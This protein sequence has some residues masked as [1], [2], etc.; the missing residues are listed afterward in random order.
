[1]ASPE[2]PAGL[3]EI[4]QQAGRVVFLTG[5]GVSAESGVPTFRDALTGL[6]SN[7]SPE[8]LATPEAF[9][10]NP[11]LVWDWYRE[12][13]QRAAK[14]QPNGGHLALARLQQRYPAA[15]L[16]TQNVDGLHQR[17]GSSGVIEFHGNLFRDRCRRCEL[18]QPGDAD[19][20]LAP[21]PCPRCGTPMGPGVV[22]FGETI[23]AR[24][25]AEAWEAASQAEVFFSIGTSGL[26]TPAAQ[27]V[28]LAREGGA[29]IVEVNTSPTALSASADFVLCGPSGVVLPRLADSLE[30]AGFLPPCGAQAGS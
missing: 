13:R 6:W 3:L 11:Q 29:W 20:C 26:V 21:P 9:L 1:V 5:S 15:T 28:E 2:I 18:E 4:L 12:R 17:A 7:F 27:L 14:V 22:W 25:L 16:I 8:E 10:R 23:P 30:A 19:A 24:A